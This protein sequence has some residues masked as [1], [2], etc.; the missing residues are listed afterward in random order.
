MAGPVAPACNAASALGV[1]TRV[2]AVAP[3]EA[4]PPTDFSSTCGGGP[5]GTLVGWGVLSGAVEAD[6]GASVAE[7]V[8]AGADAA[9]FVMLASEFDEAQPHPQY[10]T[11]KTS[12]KFRIAARYHR[13]LP[14][15]E[16]ADAPPEPRANPSGSAL[17]R[18]A[19]MGTHSTPGH[20]SC[21]RRVPLST[22]GYSWNAAAIRTHA[23]SRPI[24]LTAPRSRVQFPSREPVAN[25]VIPK[26]LVNSSLG[27]SGVFRHHALA[28]EL[29][30]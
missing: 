26:P 1:V 21:Q 24:R 4:D 25:Y 27:A 9:G 8:G 19:A 29:H 14:V 20:G 15:G 13:S 10:P 6:V 22:Q 3:G 11:T 5:G 30:H 2:P 7:A 16:F 12:T 23:T 28:R 17:E 18:A